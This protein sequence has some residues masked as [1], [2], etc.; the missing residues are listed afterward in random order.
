MPTKRLSRRSVLRGVLRTGAAVAIPLPIF[1]AMLNDHGTALAQGADLPRRYCTWFFGNGIL[2]GKWV[3]SSTA[4]DWTLSEQL[5]PL[6]NVKDWLTVVSGLRKMIPNNSPHPSGSAAATTGANV[7][8]NSASMP[9]IDQ[10]VADVNPGGDFRSLEVG[11]SDADPDGPENTLHAVSHRGPNAPN[12]PE[13]DPH[14]FFTRIFTGRTD[15]GTVDQMVKLNQVKKSILDA[16]LGD[17]AELDGLLGANDKKRL[18]DHLDAIRAIETRLETMPTNPIMIPE[19]PQIAGIGKDTKSE[20]PVAVNEVMAEMLA[21][22][23]ASDIT[24]NASFVF[25]LP[26]AH[27]FYRSLGNDMNDDFHNTIS[28]GDPG[29]SSDQPRVH[30]GVVYT[31]QALS[32][33]LGKLSMLTEGAGTVLDNS[34][35]YV[36]SCTA[37]GKNHDI[38]DWPVLFAGRAGGALKGNQHYRAADHNLSEALMT[39]AKIFGSPLTSIGKDQGK[40]SAELSGLRIG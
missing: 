1:D 26:A 28:H 9:S 25:T 24:R 33:F 17:G 19:D 21:V 12:Y 11:V 30:R 3:P 35:V 22:A 2:P 40:T 37:W 7:E 8:N 29:T 31:M 34:L 20:A 36:T 15:D 39:I 23:F 13:Y 27:A 16:V 4:A 10:I 18:S 5:A 38:I 14:A 6:A 32:V